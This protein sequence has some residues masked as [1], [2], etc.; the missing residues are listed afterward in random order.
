MSLAAV[1]RVLLLLLIKSH[2]SPISTAGGTRRWRMS[3]EAENDFLF[4][5]K[6]TLIRIWVSNS[7]CFLE[8]RNKALCFCYDARLLHK[9]AK[10]CIPLCYVS[11]TTVRFLSCS[12]HYFEL[13]QRRWNGHD[14]PVGCAGP[15]SRCSFSVDARSACGSTGTTGLVPG[16]MPQKVESVVYTWTELVQLPSCRQST[17]MQVHSKAKNPLMFG[18]C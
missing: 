12:S 9:S 10:S 13:H 5:L 1:R 7:A 18:Q 2:P 3:A 6:S 8:F 16:I 14:K 4:I 15:A 11:T 17:V